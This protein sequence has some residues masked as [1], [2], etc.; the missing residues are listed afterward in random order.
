L[1]AIALTVSAQDLFGCQVEFSNTVLFDADVEFD[2][3]ITSTG[4]IN[5]ADIECN[6]LNCFGNVNFLGPQFNVEA[7]SGSTF[8]GGLTADLFSTTSIAQIGSSLSVDGDSFLQ[9]V[10]VSGILTLGDAIIYSNSGS[11]IADSNGHLATNQPVA[12][13]A[14]CGSGAGTSGTPTL[15]VTGNDNSCTISLT[16]SI[17]PATNGDIFIFS[18]QTPFS[19]VPNVLLSAHNDN[20]AGAISNVYV[21][22]EGS[23]GFTVTAH[24]TLASTTTYMWNIHA[25]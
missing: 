3:N 4:V 25:F 12:P 14:F 21:S 24:G 7:S 18:F 15:V 9:A 20:A 11:Q 13:G 1:L 8:T 6:L 22:T 23:S 17:N 16:T 10:T 2:A 5:S 19:I